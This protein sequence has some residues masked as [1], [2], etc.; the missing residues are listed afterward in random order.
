MFCSLVD[1]WEKQNHHI[2]LQ[3]EWKTMK[4]IEKKYHLKK[5]KFLWHNTLI[6]DNIK[7]TCVCCIDKFV[8]LLIFYFL[9]TTEMWLNIIF[10]FSDVKHW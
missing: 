2:T 3:M 1:K 9:E 8:L 7:Q 4:F 10:M 5:K 6:E